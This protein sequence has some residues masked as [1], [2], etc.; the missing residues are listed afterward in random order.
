[1]KLHVKQ[2]GWVGHVTQSSTLTGW[3]LQKD[4]SCKVKFH[5]PIKLC[6]QYL[7]AVHFM[8]IRAACH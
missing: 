8:I 5:R 7:C 6:T 2:F 3:A 4:A 1:M